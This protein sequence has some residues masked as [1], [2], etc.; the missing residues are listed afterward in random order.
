MT[1]LTLTAPTTAQSA[2]DLLG[3]RLDLS[4]VRMK[5]ADAD[6]GAGLPERQL[7]L[8]EQEYRRFLALQMLHPDDDIVP[9]KI[10]DEMWHRH[11]LDT[12]AYRDDCQAIFGRFLDHFPYFGMRGPEDAQALNDAYAD[13]LRR[14]REAFGEP[15][16]GTWVA[17]DASGRCK[18]TACKPMRCR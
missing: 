6:E 11:I 16:E 14:Y 5:L 15:P 4:K 12:A 10:V 2:L 8:M 13:T 7:E 17:A 1:P 18:R 9:C 3:E